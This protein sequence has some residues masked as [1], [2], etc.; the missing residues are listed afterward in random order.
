MNNRFTR[1]SS[2]AVVA[3][4]LL[5]LLAQ[6]GQK[7]QPAKEKEPA[8]K[9]PTA[10]KPPYLGIGVEGVPPAM[11]RQMPNLKGRG[12]IIAEVAKDSPA[13]KAGLKPYDIL[14]S[15]EQQQVYSPDQFVK[16]VQN[17]KPGQSVTLEVLR[18]GKQEA[19]KVTLG[20][21]PANA[22]GQ[23]RMSNYFPPGFGA[24][25]GRG[26][27]GKDMWERFDSLNLTRIDDKRFKVDIKFRDDK[28]KVEQKHFEGTRQEIQQ[29]IQK[30]KD[31]PASEREHLLRS[32]DLGQGGY[33]SF[34]FPPMY[35]P[36]RPG[37]W[38]DSDIWDPN[39]VNNPLER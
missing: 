39:D 2:L 14:V 5:G 21:R 36:M 35:F 29:A 23:E 33:S 17:D 31:M 7:T 37:I 30:A 13:Q 3:G 24:P 6:A 11:A 16:L 19:I 18:G 32:L 38:R 25:Q 8:V 20:E 15:F 9:Q 22:W 26:M 4:L 34:M 28:G 12:V 27:Q 10:Q 1:I